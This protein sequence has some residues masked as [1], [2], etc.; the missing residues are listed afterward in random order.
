MPTPAELTSVKLPASAKAG[1]GE[2]ANSAAATIETTFNMEAIIRYF[3]NLRNGKFSAGSWPG[4]AASRAAIPGR[5][6]R[7]TGAAAIP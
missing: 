3:E 6:R 4:Q 7:N 5:D 2:V 1:A